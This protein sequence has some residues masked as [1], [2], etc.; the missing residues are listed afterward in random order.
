MSER[1]QSICGHHAANLAENTKFVL[2][3]FTAFVDLQRFANYACFTW[4]PVREPANCKDI[5]NPCPRTTRET[6]ASQSKMLWIQL[7]K[8]D[9]SY[10]HR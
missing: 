5:T 2:Q 4:Q 6:P 10:E 8:T 9:K 1:L 7:K 3:P